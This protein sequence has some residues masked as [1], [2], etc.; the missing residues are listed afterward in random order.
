M[1]AR[2]VYSNKYNVLMTEDERI[3]R[4][5]E[6]CKRMY[7]RMLLDGSWPWRQSPEDNSSDTLE[8]HNDHV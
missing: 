4:H 1:T 3:K 6:L 7:L 2:P 5:L 8:E